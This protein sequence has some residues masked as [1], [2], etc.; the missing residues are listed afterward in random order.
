ML[1]LGENIKELIEAKKKNRKPKHFKR[2]TYR[3]ISRKL[4]VKCKRS[5]AAIRRDDGQSPNTVKLK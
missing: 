4:K 5:L 1:E 2:T 3:R